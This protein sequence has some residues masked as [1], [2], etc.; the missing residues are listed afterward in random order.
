MVRISRLFP[1][2]AGLA[3]HISSS[4]FF[5]TILNVGLAST[6]VVSPCSLRQKTLP[7]YAHGETVLHWR[8]IRSFSYCGLPE[9]SRHLAGNQAHA[10]RAT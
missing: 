2:M 8:S 3:M 1:T 4:L 6:T 5:P 7:S 9:S 10:R